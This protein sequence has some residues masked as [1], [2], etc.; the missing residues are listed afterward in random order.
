MQGSRDE[1]R[2]LPI[3]RDKRPARAATGVVVTGPT[4]DLLEN[5]PPRPRVPATL[6]R[7]RLHEHKYS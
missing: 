6:H 1:E 2:P 4:G 5:R 3:D 7:K